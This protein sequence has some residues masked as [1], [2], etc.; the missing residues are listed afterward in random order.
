MNVLPTVGPV[1][2]CKNSVVPIGNRFESSVVVHSATELYLSISVYMF[3]V[4]SGS[5]FHFT[6]PGHSSDFKG[7]F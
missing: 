4:N 1:S 7:E 6:S 2:V 5:W 3:N